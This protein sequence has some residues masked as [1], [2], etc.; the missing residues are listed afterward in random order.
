M[1][2]HISI[3]SVFSQFK[4]TSFHVILMT[5]VHSREL[6][7]VHARPE[8][9]ENAALFLQLGLP[10]KLICQ[11]NGGFQKLSSNRSQN[12]KTRLFVFLWTSE[13]GLVLH[14][15]LTSLHLFP[16]ERIVQEK[17]LWLWLR[18]K[19]FSETERERRNNR[20]FLNPGF[21]NNKSKTTGDCCVFK[22]IQCSVDRNDMFSERTSVF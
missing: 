11:G 13:N 15:E 2:D 12:M 18:L 22:F 10:R 5:S 8:K 19:H 7:P 4:S 14:I 1:R 20:V 17:L 16:L 3:S 9:F 21:L 6:S